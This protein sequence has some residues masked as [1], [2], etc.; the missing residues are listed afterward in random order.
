MASKMSKLT[1]R[2]EANRA[3]LKSQA[4]VKPALDPV[5][6]KDALAGV[7]RA[8]QPEAEPAVDMRVVDSEMPAPADPDPALAT[9]G[10]G[11]T[12]PVKNAAPRKPK[13][14]KPIGSSAG[15]EA[16]L[17][18]LT[19]RAPRGTA[20]TAKINAMVQPSTIEALEE[21]ET[22]VYLERQCKL[23]RAALVTE[24]AQRIASDP[25]RYAALR[26]AG[27]GTTVVLG[28]RIPQE[29]FRSLNNAT[30]GAT[31]RLAYGPLLGLA[32][33]EIVEELSPFANP[34]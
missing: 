8:R 5:A 19:L 12:E 13:V 18:A 31:P 15:G 4:V 22:A 33:G 26:A 27:G 7:G 25:T 11:I 23:V 20:G 9:G 28:S 1:N 14:V 2:T 10:A 30:Y 17:A 21:L 3:S 34:K 6:R 24:A 32:I 16:L 29:A